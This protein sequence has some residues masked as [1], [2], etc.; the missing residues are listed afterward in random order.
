MCKTVIGRDESLKVSAD[1]DR[2]SVPGK[3]VTYLPTYTASAVRRDLGTSYLVECIC[4]SARQSWSMW[5]EGCLI[6][7]LELCRPMANNWRKPPIGLPISVIQQFRV[8]ATKV[9][10]AK[11]S[12]HLFFL[13]DLVCLCIVFLMSNFAKSNIERLGRQRPP[14]FKT[15]WTEIGFV[16]VITPCLCRYGVS[17]LLDQE[18]YSYIH[19]FSCFRSMLMKDTS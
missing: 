10:V 18:T 12:L 9:Q 8:E 1:K 6:S 7:I 11:W 17:C 2:G 3:V 5:R 19:D 16:Y 4:K 14:Q 15:V 13:F